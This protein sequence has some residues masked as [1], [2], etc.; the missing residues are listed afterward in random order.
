MMQN[1]FEQLPLSKS[2][3]TLEGKIGVFWDIFGKE[4]NGDIGHSGSDPGIL[5]FMYFGPVSGIGCVLTTNTD[6][7]KRQKEVVEIWKLLI[8]YRK[9]F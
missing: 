6:S 1:Q 8:K 4:G 5:S 9:D 2:T 3:A 7:H